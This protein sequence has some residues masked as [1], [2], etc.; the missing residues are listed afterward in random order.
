M[1]Q[2]SIS[3]SMSPRETVMAMYNGLLTSDR[4]VLQ[5]ITHPDIEIHVTE[6]LPYGG[7]YRGLAG[8]QDLFRNTFGLIR[9]TIEIENVFDAGSRVV[10]VGRTRGN[11]NATGQYFDSAIVHVLTVENGMIV[12]FDAFVEDAP[13]AAAI[14]GTPEG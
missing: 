12:R 8:F 5:A 3:G 7:D 10:A 14:H 9:S 6:E 2:P 11:G 13:I 1:S 4:E